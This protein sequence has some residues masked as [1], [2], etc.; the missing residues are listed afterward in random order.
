MKY[1]IAAA[2][3]PDSVWCRTV[4]WRCDRYGRPL[5]FASKAKAQE[6]AQAFNDQRGP[7][8]H[9]YSNTAEPLEREEARP[10]PLGM[11]C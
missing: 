10:Q 4:K 8:S 5:V 6:A 3:R 9:I 2:T 11:Q 7:F 1:G